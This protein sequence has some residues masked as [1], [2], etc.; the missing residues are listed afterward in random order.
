ME[1]VTLRIYDNAEGLIC[2]FHHPPE[3]GRKLYR[4]LSSDLSYTN[5]RIVLFG[6]DGQPLEGEAPPTGRQR[7]K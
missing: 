5:Y 3:A 6:T 7:K 1:H 2:Q 4:D